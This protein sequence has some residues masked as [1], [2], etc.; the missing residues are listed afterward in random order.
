V[1]FGSGL[2]RV[3]VS[4]ARCC[5]VPWLWKEPIGGRPGAGGPPVRQ[6]PAADRVSRRGHAA[7]RTSSG[8][9]T[10]SPFT[11]LW[12]LPGGFP[13]A[14]PLCPCPLS[15]LVETR[16]L[17]MSGDGYCSRT[18]GSEVTSAR[19]SV[20]VGAGRQV[21][22]PRA[23]LARNRCARFSDGGVAI[24]VP[25]RAMEALWSATT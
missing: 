3:V 24:R 2:V 11:P 12:R 15:A 6:R 10:R 20:P 21:R 13:V 4:T 1:L 18:A 19:C 14:G 16:R 7:F 9:R 8:L 25:S 23:R 5:D 22:R 17:E